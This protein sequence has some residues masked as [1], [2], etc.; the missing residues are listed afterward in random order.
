MYY[1]PLK[2][3]LNELEKIVRARGGRGL[4][5][6]DI[7]KE[8]VKCDGSFQRA[9]EGHCTYCLPMYFRDHDKDDSPQLEAGDPS[10][11]LG[12]VNNTQGATA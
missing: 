3:N 2:G 9:R 1:C 7:R 6:E 5:P 4:S 10:P 11:I 12:K 8:C